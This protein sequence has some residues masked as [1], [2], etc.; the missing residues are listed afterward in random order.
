MLPV[1]ASVPAVVSGKPLVSRVVYLRKKAAKLRSMIGKESS[2][3]ER[4]AL[5][6]K[7]GELQM[8]IVELAMNPLEYEL[9][10]EEPWAMECKIYE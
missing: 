6:N 10:V 8:E 5:E 3:E 1:R 9:C 4:R 2:F 7:L